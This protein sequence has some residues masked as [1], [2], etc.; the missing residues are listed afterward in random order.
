MAAAVELGSPLAYA[1]NII[2]FDNNASS[3]GGSTL[4]STNG[5]LGYT[6]TNAFD[7]STLDSWF[8]IDAETPPINRLPGTQTSAEP[9][10]GA[11]QFLVVNNTGATVTSFSIT[12]NL[13]VVHC[14]GR[15]P[16]L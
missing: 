9:N 15:P 4:C 16:A 10:G 3:C 12:L 2:T 5:T 6:G 14:F 8:Q 11:G 7:L 13:H 1:A